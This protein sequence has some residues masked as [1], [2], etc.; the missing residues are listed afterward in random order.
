MTLHVQQPS[1]QVIHQPE[2]DRF[3]MMVE[4]QTAGFAE[5]RETGAQARAFTHTEIDESFQGQGLAKQLVTEALDLTREQGLTVLP[6]CP[7]VRSFIAK[8][9]EYLQLVPAE[10]R[11]EFGL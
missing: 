1:T 8:H 7:L 6:Y 3:A 11:H 5:Y 9:S 2:Q 4:A 10:R